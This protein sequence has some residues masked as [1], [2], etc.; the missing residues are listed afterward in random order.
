MLKFTI[1]TK[2][3][4]KICPSMVGEI[5]KI[6]KNGMALISISDKHLPTEE[7]AICLENWEII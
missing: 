1:G 4:N 7:M 6:Y 3:K 5:S 2:L